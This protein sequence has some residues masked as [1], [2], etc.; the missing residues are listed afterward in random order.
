MAPCTLTLTCYL[1]DTTLTRVCT[2]VEFSETLN[3]KPS[4]IGTADQGLGFLPLTLCRFCPR[5]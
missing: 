2:G 3:R 1:N 4:T 5:P